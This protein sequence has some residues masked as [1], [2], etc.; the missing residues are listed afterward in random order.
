MTQSAGHQK[1]DVPTKAGGLLHM[2]PDEASEIDYL[3]SRNRP[4]WRRLS[5]WLFGVLALTAV[6]L[7]VLRFSSIEHFVRL[8]HTARPGWFLAAFLAQSLGYVCT[9]IVWRQALRRAGHPRPLR[10]LLPLGIAKQFTDQVVPSGGVSGAMLVARGL[11]RRQVPTNVA[12]AVLLVGL[13]SYFGAYLT[14]ALTSVGIL[15]AYERA[16][17]PLLIGFGIF[18]AVAVA[19]PSVVL[20]AIHSAHRLPVAWF[21]RLPDAVLL[22][23][24]LLEAPTHLLRD[25]VLLT[26]TIP[27]EL[28]DFVLDAL[29][30]WFVFCALGEIP[31]IWIAFVS[32]MTASMAA[33]LGPIPLGLGTFEAACVAMLSLLGVA[34]ETGLSATLLLRGLTFWIPMLPGLWL[35]RTEIMR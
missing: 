24:A 21:R 35:A 6:V 12:V 20:W 8:A 15:W 22:R 5:P 31:P 19:V 32:F 9:G 16:N 25:P 33:T 30:F 10:S 3:A 11:A 29:T 27:L 2:E 28:A 17:T 4:M 13:V 26:Q 7:V 1:D 34:I 23:K 14:A 18:V